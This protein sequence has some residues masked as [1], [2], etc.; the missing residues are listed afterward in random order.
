MADTAQQ[1]APHGDVDHRFGHVDAL[2][3]IA[4]QTTPSGKSA[5]GSFNDPSARQHLESWLDVDAAHYL[6]DEIEKGGLVHQLAAVVCTIG[7]QMFDPRPTLSDRIEDHLRADTVKN[8]GL[9]MIDHQQTSIGVN[10]NMPL[11]PHRLLGRVIASLCPGRWG[12][13]GLAVDDASAR[14][15]FA[16]GPLTI[17]H[18]GDVV[19]SA[20][21]HQPYEAP[22]PPIHRLPGREVLRKHSPAAAR[23]RHI[24][25][26][27]EYLAQVYARLAPTLGRFRQQ[28]LYLLP[29]FIR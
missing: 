9:G 16:P 18:Q 6:D 3:V 24:A 8:V 26:R 21:K 29:F 28:G 7:K 22:K 23:A 10:R 2:F 1:Q 11:A 20:K 12:L 5:E 14:A 4:H 19:D 27:V 17:Q 25:D 13:Y 15:R